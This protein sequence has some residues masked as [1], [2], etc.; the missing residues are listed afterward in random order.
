MS[1]KTALFSLATINRTVAALLVTLAVMLIAVVLWGLQQ[2]QATYDSAHDYYRVRE[3]LSGHWRSTIENYLHGGDGVQ[4][5]AAIKQLTEIRA[6]SLA[7]LPQPLQ[8]K[9]LPQM[10]ALEHSLNI[11]LRAA[12]KLAG[13]PQALL[14][15][16][17]NELRGKLSL[18][19]G[20]A[21]ESRAAKPALASDYLAKIAAMSDALVQ[22]VLA[23]ERHS[24]HKK[25]S[26]ADHLEELA[27]LQTQLHELSPLNVFTT[28]NDTGFELLI[29]GP[30]SPPEEK[31]TEMRREI[32][33]ILYRY[34]AELDSTDRQLTAAATAR[35]QVREQI[36]A[37]LQNLSAYDEDIAQNQSAIRQQV[38]TRLFALIA[39]LLGL[40][41]GVFFLQYRLG[42]IALRVGQFLQQ[43][44]SGKL[45]GSLQLH[46]RINEIQVLGKSAEI[47]QESMI[48]LNQALKR[49][50]SEVSV[51]SGA[52][53]Q[54]AR[55]LQGNLD[56]QLEQSTRAST[57]VVQM[58]TTSQTVA[59]EVGAVVAATI[60]ADKTLQSGSRTI[61][62]AV[63]GMSSLAVE[64]AAAGAALNQLQ[65][66][67]IS[68]QSFVSHIQGIADQ[69]NLLALNAAIEA[70]RAGEQGRGFAVVAEEV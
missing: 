65:Q 40:C 19:A 4:L 62:E 37:L 39:I 41:G 67:G 32:G 36:G 22:L 26:V 54:A 5:D 52:V 68:I 24:Q 70:A 25:A 56:E 14:A 42:A 9:L 31:S 16:A 47:L 53:L 18:L 48:D 49:R 59:S 38:K 34:P 64:I 35:T 44:A 17:E 15:N 46:S 55:E 27:E 58:S 29:A 61:G 21:I 6:Q 30:T 13:Q 45:H 51:A 12:G 69:T 1:E 7:T 2:L 57:A 8:E 60:E 33:S 28:A 23:R 43:M 10:A 3:S 50:S 63:S 66:H 11:D 20:I